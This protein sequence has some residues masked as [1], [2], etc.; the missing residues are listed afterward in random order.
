MQDNENGVTSRKR[1]QRTWCCGRGKWG[2][3]N[4]GKRRSRTM[5]TAWRRERG[6]SGLGAVGWEGEAEWTGGR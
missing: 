2:R 1:A 4:R 3:M 6:L 5:R